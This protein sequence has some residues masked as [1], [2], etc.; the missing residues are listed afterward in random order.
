MAQSFLQKVSVLLSAS[1]HSLLDRALQ[2]NSLAVFDEYIRQAE[3]SMETLRSSLIDLASSVKRLRTKYDESA[4]EAAELDLQIDAALKANKMVVAKAA[5]TKFNAQMNIARTYQDQYEKQ[6]ATFKTLQEVVEVL[7]AKVDVLKS[8]REQV[9]TLLELIRSK[10]L[11]A[12]SIKDIQQISDNRTAAIV[13]DVKSQL[14]TADVRLESAT[15][16][17]SDQ[18]DQEVGD[19]TLDAQ[20]E[21]RRNRL[22]LS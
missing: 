8:Q 4:D 22:G 18:I 19:A 15:S 20:L 12:R 2:S 13:E 21:E 10:N 3:D 14:D 17:L 9:A 5:Q 7:Q 11:I 16:R 1:L 6:S